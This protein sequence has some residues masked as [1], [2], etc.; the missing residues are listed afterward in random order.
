MVRFKVEVMVE[1]QKE[2]FYKNTTYLSLDE[3]RKKAPSTYEAIISDSSC[4]GTYTKVECGL[5]YRITDQERINNIV[6]E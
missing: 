3:L 6:I 1:G 4:V 5:R 2:A